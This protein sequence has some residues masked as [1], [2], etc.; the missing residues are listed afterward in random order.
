MPNEWLICLFHYRKL[1]HILL[2]YIE[3]QVAIQNLSQCDQCYPRSSFKIVSVELIQ[4]WFSVLWLVCNLLKKLLDNSF[5]L[6]PELLVQLQQALCHNVRLLLLRLELGG[7]SKLR[8]NYF[9]FGFLLSGSNVS[10]KVSSWVYI[11][12]SCFQ[13][14][15]LLSNSKN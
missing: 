1:W 6:Y 13:I 3:V 4:K 15:D 7:A 5:S 8:V 2:R 10:Q 9:Q 11:K 14:S 12:L